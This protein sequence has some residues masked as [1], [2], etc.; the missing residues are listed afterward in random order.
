MDGRTRRRTRR[1]GRSWHDEATGWGSGVSAA[2]RPASSYSRVRA[3]PRTW[4]ATWP[5]VQEA[6]GLG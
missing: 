2:R 1:R 4:W 5:C 6:C 3:V